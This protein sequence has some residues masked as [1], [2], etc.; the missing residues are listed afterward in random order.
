MESVAGDICDA[1][2][3]AE[4]EVTKHQVPKQE[5]VQL[6]RVELISIRRSLLS[7]YK[8]LDKIE[9]ELLIVLDGELQIVRRSANSLL[10]QI[11]R[12]LGWRRKS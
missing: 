4:T 2:I 3:E 12:L 1:E 11:D 7:L 6:S 8:G 5:G 10:C 9:P